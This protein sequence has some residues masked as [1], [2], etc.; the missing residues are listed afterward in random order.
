MDTF[1][2]ASGWLVASLFFSFY[3][4]RQLFSNLW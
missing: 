3:V 1:F 4:N 2:T